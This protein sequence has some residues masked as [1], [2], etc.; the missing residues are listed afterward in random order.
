MLS[1]KSVNEEGDKGLNGHSHIVPRIV[2]DGYLKMCMQMWD[3]KGGLSGVLERLATC[4]A[5]LPKTR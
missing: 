1:R 3:G 2:K 5:P 4:S